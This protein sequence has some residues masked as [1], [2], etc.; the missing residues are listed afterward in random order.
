[1]SVAAAFH[2]MSADSP[3][4]GLPA[5]GG[6]APL[7]NIPDRQQ[8]DGF[9]QPVIRREYSV[10]AMPVLPRRRHEIGEPVEELK[11]R[12]LDDAIGPRSRGRSPAAGADPVGGFMPWKRVAH[13]RDSA[14]RVAD[15]GE[16]LQCEG[17][18]GALS[19]QVLETPKITRHVAVDER[20]PDTGVDGKP[21]F[22]HA[23]PHE[24]AVAARFRHV[25]GQ[26]GSRPTEG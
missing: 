23:S 26:C 2:G 6:V 19:Q 18:P 1:M 3:A 11:R 22:C 14:A 12:E 15:H 13:A 5:G 25:F 9:P 21:G 20:D 8:R 17:R 24:I 16:S 10:I 4:G 7:A